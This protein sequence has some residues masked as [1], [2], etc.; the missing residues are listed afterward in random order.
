MWPRHSSGTLLHVEWVEMIRRLVRYNSAN[1]RGLYYANLRSIPA[2]ILC[3]RDFKNL[4]T[5]ESGC[6]FQFLQV[7]ECAFLMP[8]KHHP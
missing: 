6:A 3:F 7:P 4:P 5:H 8:A 2:G 1:F